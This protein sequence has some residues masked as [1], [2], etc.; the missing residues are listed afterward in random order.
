MNLVT[1]A[2]DNASIK[3]SYF[4]SVLF[5]LIFR[6]LQKETSLPLNYISITVQY[7]R[8]KRKDLLL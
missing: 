4:N 3:E 7:Q 1:Y 2:S 6:F 5:Y 8:T